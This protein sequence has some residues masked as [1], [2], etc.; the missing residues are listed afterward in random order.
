VSDPLKLM[1]MIST[2]QV[3]LSMAL[4]TRTKL[5]LSVHATEQHSPVAQRPGDHS[6]TQPRS[7]GHEGRSTR[8]AVDT[9]E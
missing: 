7:M 1:L 4:K 5:S 8:P 2:T 3:L 6:F 9:G